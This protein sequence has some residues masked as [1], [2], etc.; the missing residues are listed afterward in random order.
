M[1]VIFIFLLSEQ[2]GGNRADV[3]VYL[4]DKVVP[5]LLLKHKMKMRGPPA[6]PIQLHQEFPNRP[7]MRNRVTDGLNTLEPEPPLL[8]RNHDAPL[9]RLIPARV[10]DIV[11][12]GAVGLPDVDF[13][14]GYRVAVAVLD[15]ADAEEWFALRVEGHVSAVVEGRRVVGVEGPE[16]GAFGRVGG[17][18]VVDA[19]DEEGEA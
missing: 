9:T 8:V 18:G 14:P 13:Y 11:V 15:G 19:V 10:L 3:G 17:F 16:D 1:S 2:I 6:M 4:R 5:A 7:I 12:A